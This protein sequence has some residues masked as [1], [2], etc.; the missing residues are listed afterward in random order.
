LNL[1]EKL[2]SSLEREKVFK[3]AETI[4]Q[5][6]IADESLSEEQKER[7]AIILART[8]AVQ[9][10]LEEAANLYERYWLSKY[11]TR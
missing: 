3:K 5:S 1:K 2:F 7:I 11:S 9:G 8:Y 4:G 10:K 6:Y